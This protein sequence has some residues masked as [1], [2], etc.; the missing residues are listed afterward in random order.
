MKFC[1][2]DMK[3]V[4]VHVCYYFFQ[5]RLLITSLYWGRQTSEVRNRGNT[6]RDNSIL[7]RLTH[8]TT[9]LGELK[10]NNGNTDGLLQLEKKNHQLCTI[11]YATKVSPILLHLSVNMCTHLSLLK[12]LKANKTSIHFYWFIWSILHDILRL[13]WFFPWLFC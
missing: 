9:G 12:I 4:F 7:L 11:L 8:T 5:P 13:L 10:C 6:R 3:N 2:T 1:G